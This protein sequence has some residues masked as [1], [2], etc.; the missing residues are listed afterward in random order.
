LFVVEGERFEHGR[1][2]VLFAT[3]SQEVLPPFTAG[4]AVSAGGTRFLLRSAW[5]A[6][7]PRL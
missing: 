6:L 1:K 5:A 3:R 7:R 4:Y 2:V